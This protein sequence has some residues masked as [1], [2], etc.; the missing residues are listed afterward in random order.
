M[1]HRG[2]QKHAEIPINASNLCRGGPLF[3]RL[4]LL[5]FHNRPA[6]APAVLTAPAC[7]GRQEIGI[8]CLRDD[9]LK[10]M[11]LRLEMRRMNNGRRDGTCLTR[12]VRTAW[13]LPRSRARNRGW[14]HGAEWSHSTSAEVGVGYSDGFLLHTCN[15]LIWARCGK[16]PVRGDKSCMVQIRS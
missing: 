11:N 15:H 6:A 5:N 7:I 1:D 16:H 2:Q 8:Q 10:E 3:S 9:F 4:Y 13:L 12:A 14:D